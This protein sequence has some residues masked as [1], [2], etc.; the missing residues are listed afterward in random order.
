MDATNAT[1]EVYWEEGIQRLP[2]GEGR[3]KKRVANWPFQ[4]DLIHTQWEDI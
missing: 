2:L 1:W 4:G 3:V